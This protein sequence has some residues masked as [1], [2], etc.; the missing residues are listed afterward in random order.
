MS[1]PKWNDISDFA[2]F[3]T[4]K[5]DECMKRGVDITTQNTV[6]KGNTDLMRSTI[7]IA[8]NTGNMAKTPAFYN[9]SIGLLGKGAIA[10]WT[11]AELSKNPPVIPAPGTVLN[12]SVVSNTVTNPGVW[13]TTPLPLLPSNSTDPFIDGFIL[14]GS[15]HLQSISGICNTI[16]QYPPPAAPGPGI[17]LWSGFTVDPAKTASSALAVSNPN[18]SSAEK[19]ARYEELLKMRAAIDEELFTNPNPDINAKLDGIQSEINAYEEQL[20]DAI[21]SQKAREIYEK[22]Y[23]NRIYDGTNVDISAMNSKKRTITS[24]GG[25]SKDRALYNAYGNGEWPARGTYPN[26][27][28]S[29]KTA[30]QTW[31]EVNQKYIAKNCVK[32]RLPTSTGS[33]DVILHRDF[34][35]IVNRSISE[36]KQQGLQKYIRNPQ[37]GM[38]VRSVTNGIRLSNHSWGLALDLADNTAYPYGCRYTSSGIYK[39]STKIR[40]L[41]AN[42]IGF[43]KVIDIFVK[44]GCT[45]LSGND[46]MHVSIAE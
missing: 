14:M 40:D 31:Y 33:L 8:L 9:Q 3:F 13:P 2:D 34:A 21:A 16:S 15:I 23:S 27:D 28:V 44:N 26:F 10:Y 22:L 6:V 18:T 38:V 11:G 1:N 46:P 36:I 35:S 32:V 7:I 5:Y 25:S 45:W 30:T 19:K 37:G 39:G 24:N 29:F 43:K 41:N 42:D 17:I 4:K 12:L 20:A